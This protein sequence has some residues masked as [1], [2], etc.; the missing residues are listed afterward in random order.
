MPKHD[1][2]S[3]KWLGN[4]MKSKGLQRLRWY[5]QMCEKQCRDQNGFQCH[6]TS[7]AHL[8]NMQ[9]FLERPAD[10]IDSFSAEFEKSFMQL[11]STRYCRAPKIKAN[12]VYMD[13]I[14]DRDHQHMNSTIWTTLGSFV[15]YLMR[16]DKVL[17]ERDAKGDWLITYIDRSP[18][19]MRRQ[20]DRKK[21]EEKA[22]EAADEEE[23]HLAKMVEMGKLKS[24]EAENVTFSRRDESK[25]LVKINLG[26]A[27]GV[28]SSSGS[29]GGLTKKRLGSIFGE[30]EEKEGLKSRK[31]DATTVSVN[32]VN[33]EDDVEASSF[34][35]VPGLSVKV[36]NKT[37]RNG[38][39]Y[40]RKGHV[41][42]VPQPGLAELEVTLEGGKIKRVQ[43]PEIEL[44]TVIPRVGGRVT[45]V[46]A[47]SRS[48]GAPG[49]LEAVDMDKFCCKVKVGEKSMWLDYEDVCKTTT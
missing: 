3:A 12:L 1:V 4:K 6:Q 36:R 5:C 47:G 25:G 31:I 35:V 41:L 45:V 21:A 11:L 22:A 37:L 26:L 15:E 14:R 17:G 27:A 38:A 20:A 10:L 16:T 2:G 46:G 19:E 29:S 39:Y 13:F 28:S 7:E 32:D 23:V 18:E 33:S 9:V 30:G 40:G 43:I 42:S 8:R 49:V 48:R 44:E 34:W 24:S